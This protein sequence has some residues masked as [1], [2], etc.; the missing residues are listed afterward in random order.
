MKIEAAVATNSKLLEANILNSTVTNSRGSR[1]SLGQQTEVAPSV[2]VAVGA[3]TQQM[4]AP[5]KEELNVK[6]SISS[7]ALSIP[8]SVPVSILGSSATVGPTVVSA[9]MD[10]E[11]LFL[12][13]PLLTPKDR[14]TITQFFSETW[15]DTFTPSFRAA[16][17]VLK[18][19]LQSDEKVDVCHCKCYVFPSLSVSPSLSLFSIF[20]LLCLSLSIFLFP[21][22]S[23]SYMDYLSAY[24]QIGA[25]GQ[26]IKETVYL[27]LEFS[28]H[29][30]KKVH[31]TVHSLSFKT[32][33]LFS[34]FYSRFQVHY[35][36]S[37]HSFPS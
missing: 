25:D 19:K 18:I 17:P 6:P 23:I 7:S 35:Y 4:F 21:P 31:T 8:S 16:N 11:T 12:S 3:V 29:S 5:F 22:M 10:I 2:R 34:L 13:S 26:K 30:W 14:K 27:H 24:C 33:F 32:F 28:P 1:D 36:F 37:Y 20:S 15:P 9:G